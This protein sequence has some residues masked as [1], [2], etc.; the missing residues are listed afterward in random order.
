LLTGISGI[1][2]SLIGYVSDAFDWDF[3]LMLDDLD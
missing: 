1:G 2:L 3:C